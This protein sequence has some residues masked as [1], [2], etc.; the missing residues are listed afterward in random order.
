MIEKGLQIG[1]RDDV[2]AVLRAVPD[3]SVRMTEAGSYLFPRLPALTLALHDF[4]R[5]VRLQANAVVTPGT[6]FSPDATD[7]IRLNF[8]QNHQAAVQ[9]AQRIAQLIERYR[10]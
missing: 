3:L 1:V 8:S 7:S 4:V 2:I 9:A 5:A 10:E 6:E